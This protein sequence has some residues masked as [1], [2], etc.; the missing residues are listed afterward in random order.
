M[1]RDFQING[2]AL[3]KVKGGANS[4]ISSLS[5]L[6]LSTEQIQVAF[7]YRHVPLSVEMNGQIPVDNQF[8]GTMATVSFVLGH[9][10]EAVLEACMIEAMGLNSNTAAIGSLPMF[11]ARLGNNVARFA[12]GNHYIGL[13]ILSPVAS[14]PWRFYFAYLAGSPVTYPLGA[15]KSQVGIVFQCIPYMTDPWNGGNGQSGQFLFDRTL[16]T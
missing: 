14:R 10:D 4:S 9:F 11:G 13:N 5:E 7:D 15:G 3:I 1:S 8:F 2:P 6:G 12:A 16:D